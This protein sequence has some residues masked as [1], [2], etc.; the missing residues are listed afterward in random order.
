M[1]SLQ[2]LYMSLFLAKTHAPIPVGLPTY[3][4][5]HTGHMHNVHTHARTHAHTHTHTHT[6]THYRLAPLLSSPV[7]SCLLVRWAYHK[8]EIWQR[9]GGQVGRSSATAGS[10]CTPVG[11]HRDACVFMWCVCVCV[12]VCVHV[13]MATCTHKRIRKG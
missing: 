12:C 1:I 8:W 6:H 4:W 13:R 11:C 7:T 10:N 9:E 5:T 2:L 3:I